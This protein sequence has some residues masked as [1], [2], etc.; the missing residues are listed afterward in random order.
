MEGRKG[1][2]RLIYFI[3]ESFHTNTIFF[4]R[5]SFSRL[6]WLLIFA[7]SCSLE[8]F[9]TSEKA[10]L[11]SRKWA[12]NFD[13]LSEV[14]R[15]IFRKTFGEKQLEGLRFFRRY[16]SSENWKFLTFVGK[17]DSSFFFSTTLN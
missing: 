6:V 12:E 9:L 10:F 15:K 14:R 13:N 16:H 7:S 17:S 3:T 1:K 2:P 8:V 4:A 5:V 11:F